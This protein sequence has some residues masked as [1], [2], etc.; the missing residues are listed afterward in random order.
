M[1]RVIYLFVSFMF[2]LSC[3]H[4]AVKREGAV[5]HS[6]ASPVTVDEGEDAGD[7]ELPGIP[8]TITDPGARAA[9]LMAHFWDNL[10]FLDRSLSIDTAF[11]EQNFANFLSLLPHVDSTGVA[12]AMEAMVTGASASHDASALL[13]QVAEKYLADPNSPMRDGDAYIAYARAATEHSGLSRVETA[14]MR[15]LAEGLTINRPGRRAADFTYLTPS[16]GSGRLHAYASRHELTLLLFHDP[17][18]ESCREVIGILRTSPA[19]GELVSAGRLGVIAVYPDGDRD[20]WLG[21]VGEIPAGW[22]AGFD[23]GTIAERDLYRL[24]AL[25]SLYLLDASSRVLLRDATVAEALAAIEA[26]ASGR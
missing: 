25:P 2:I 12:E 23:D 8:A 21:R 14:R 24:P 5:T 6:V 10:D 3:S 11:M 4:A 17:D 20:L 16:G 18:C 7:L 26:A 1:I 15:W 9:Y 22:E 19:V 13:M